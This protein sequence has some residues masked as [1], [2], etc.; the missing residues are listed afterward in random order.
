MPDAAARCL[1]A[2]L[3]SEDDGEEEGQQGGA[4]LIRCMSLVARAAIK[5]AEVDFRKRQPCSDLI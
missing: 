4:S 3:S 2:T 1:A 5:S